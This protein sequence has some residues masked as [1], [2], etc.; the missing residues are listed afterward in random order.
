MKIADIRNFD[1]QLKFIAAILCNF[2]YGGSKMKGY[3]LSILRHGMT[4]ANAKGIYIGKTDTPLSDKGAAQLA[5]KMDEFDYP[6][7][8]R[9]YSSPLRRCTETAEILFPH[10]RICVVDDLRELDFGI[11][12]NKSVDELVKREDYM[13]WIKGGKD[14][15]PPQ[16]ESL[17]ELTARTYK[18]LHEIITDMMNDGLTHC[19][20]IT[21]GG[22]ISNMLSCYGLPKYNPAELTADFGEGFDAIATAQMWLNSQAIEIL[23]YCPYEKIQDADDFYS[24]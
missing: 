14:S 11:F 22:V 18:A 24:I 12:E 3:R 19:A 23:G 6:T 2:I 16:G 9:V 5:A 17:Q 4:E 21:H 8:H 7:V 20:V 10:T 1:Q 15:R 13:K